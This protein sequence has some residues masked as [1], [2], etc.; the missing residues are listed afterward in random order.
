MHRLNQE[1]RLIFDIVL[2]L[3]VSEGNVHTQGLTLEYFSFFLHRVASPRNVSI[4]ELVT[5]LMEEIYGR[6]TKTG[7]TSGGAGGGGTSGGAGGGC[8]DSG[9]QAESA[10]MRAI[11]LLKDMCQKC[12]SSQGGGPTCKNCGNSV[13]GDGTPSG[14][15]TTS[16]F[17]GILAQKRGK[18]AD[19]EFEKLSK[20]S[21]KLDMP[22]DEVQKKKEEFV[23]KFDTEDKGTLKHSEFIAGLRRHCQ[24]DEKEE[25]PSELTKFLGEGDSIGFEDYLKW[26]YLA[27]YSEPM[28]VTD[29]QERHLRLL[30]RENGFRLPDVEKIKVVFDQYDVDRSGE[31]DEEEFKGVLLLLMKVTNP[32][33]ISAKKLKR[34]WREVDQD[35]SG[36][37]T[38][39]EFVLWYFNCF[40]AKGG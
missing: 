13:D 9:G 31:I 23:E 14:Q 27:Q 4:Q 26:S 37:V 7:G 30:A 11:R 33:H 1:I 32:E 20:L 17:A 35:M 36:A 40:L 12:G 29:P 34:F 10:Q 6:T 22:M 25:I 8:V 21:R 24:M 3:Q 28:L 19:T 38:F 39:G 15:Q 16:G 18:G 2:Q 5:F